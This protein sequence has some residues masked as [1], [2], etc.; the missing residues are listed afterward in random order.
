MSAIV[1]Q[2][3]LDQ[4]KQLPE[5]DRLLLEQRLAE[6]ADAEWRRAATDAR[7]SARARGIDQATIDL[8]IEEL[9]R[10]A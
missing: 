8:A 1:V 9:R 6:L 5:D 10:P 4:I 2:E 3:I 7:D